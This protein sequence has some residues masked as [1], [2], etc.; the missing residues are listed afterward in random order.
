MLGLV[1][2]VPF[3]DKIPLILQGSVRSESL[4]INGRCGL[5]IHGQVRPLWLF[6]TKVNPWQGIYFCISA[7]N[8]TFWDSSREVKVQCKISFSFLNRKHLV[9]ASSISAW[10]TPFLSSTHWWQKHSKV[11]AVEP[12]RAPIWSKP[13]SQ[14]ASHQKKLLI[15]KQ[16]HPVGDEDSTSKQ[17]LIPTDPI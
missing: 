10:K 17:M 9:R 1:S 13:P 5:C 14:P 2:S 6:C 16:C 8:Q 11:E 7:E 4:P 12:Y 3:S 15:G